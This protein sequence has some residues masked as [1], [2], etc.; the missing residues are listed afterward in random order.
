MARDATG[1][2]RPVKLKFIHLKGGGLNHLRDYQWVR[3]PSLSPPCVSTSMFLTCQRVLAYCLFAVSP[4]GLL[5][6]VSNEVEPF[7]RA[8]ITRISWRPGGM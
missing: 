6:T 3:E 8:I 5:G 4:D 7:R 2:A 1:I